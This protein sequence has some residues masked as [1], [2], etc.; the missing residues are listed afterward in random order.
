[1]ARL[2]LSRAHSNGIQQDNYQYAIDLLRLA[3]KSF[4]VGPDELKELNFWLGFS[5]YTW[6]NNLQKA[7]TVEMAKRTLPMFQEAKQLFQSAV[8]YGRVGDQINQYLA[9]TDVF[10]EIQNARIKR[11]GG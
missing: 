9:N 8:G 1:M 10:I 2:I 3:K 11:G 6:G 4:D 7:E 5:L